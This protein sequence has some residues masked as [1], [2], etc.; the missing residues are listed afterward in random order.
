MTNKPIGNN[1]TASL[2]KQIIRA[3]HH[4]DPNKVTGHASRRTSATLMAD[5]GLSLCQIK[6]LPRHKSDS[7]VQGYID[8]GKKQELIVVQLSRPITSLTDLLRRTF[9]TRLL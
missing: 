9:H 7:V 5:A 2:L 8:K 1:T 4:P 3:V 6:A